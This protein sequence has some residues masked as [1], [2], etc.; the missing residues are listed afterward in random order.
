MTAG[1]EGISGRSRRLLYV[2]TISNSLHGFIGPIATHFRTLGWT[3]DGMARNATTCPRCRDTFDNVF[4]A[5]W[6]RS[7]LDFRSLLAAVP[8]IRQIVAAGSYDFVHVHTPVAA[9]ITRYALRNRKLQS[10]PAVIYTAHGFHFH[11]CGKPFQNHVFRSLERLAGRWTNRLVV[12]NRTDE[13]AAAEYR[14]VPRDRIHYIP[15]IGIDTDLYAPHSVS[16]DD[17]EKVRTELGIGPRD[18][19]LLMLAEFNPGKRHA[20]AVRALAA[21]GI[22]NVHLALAGFGPTEAAVRAL[23]RQ[24]GLA[25]RV[26][27]LG[28]RNDV[29]ALLR[30][31]VAL[32]LPSIREGLSRSVMESLSLE[33]PVLGTRIRGILDLVGEDAGM[34]VSP[35]D[36]EGLARSMR[37][38]AEHPSE[39]SQMGKIGRR[40]MQSQFH[41]RE[42]IRGHEDLY[43]K[44]WSD[45]CPAT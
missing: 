22:P 24:R 9:F 18:P 21:S 31:S 36:I 23:A 2:T 27:F 35:G 5:Q 32:I 33:V 13:K 10:K 12:I 14:I 6:S 28:L 16:P 40:R 37:W 29:S 17:V 8:K 11:P 34:L 45:L 20:D 39:A 30:A 41:V 38:M 26:H 19:L 25:S 44:S 4:E 43:Q 7:P 1:N 42:V 15:G 3:V